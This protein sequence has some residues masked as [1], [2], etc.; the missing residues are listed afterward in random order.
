MNATRTPTVL[1]WSLAL[2]LVFAC[3]VT[4]SPAQSATGDDKLHFS[5]VLDASPL[6]KKFNEIAKLSV[7]SM[8]VVKEQLANLNSSIEANT[9]AI[10]QLETKLQEGQQKQV[11]KL[12]DVGKLVERVQLAVAA[13]PKNPV[14]Y[15]YYI[16][17]TPSEKRAK[18]LGTEGWELITA[19]TDNWL[20]FKK[21]V[22]AGRP[23]QPPPAE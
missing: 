6:S 11:Q 14:S 8:S 1:S 12:D 9:K 3:C 10:Q 20:I 13:L 4:H 19:T 15:D 21:P 16:L 23:T 7:L 5:A 22:Y 2:G 17:R 18:E